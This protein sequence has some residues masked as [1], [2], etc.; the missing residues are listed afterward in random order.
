MHFN[1]KQTG[2]AS[3]ATGCYDSYCGVW[4]RL[5]GFT[6]GVSRGE[7]GDSYCLRGV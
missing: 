3:T 1:Y 2:G 5:A 6:V 4:I 7:R